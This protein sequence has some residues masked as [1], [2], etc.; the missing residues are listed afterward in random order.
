VIVAA[1]RDKAGEA[2]A[3]GAAQTFL[4]QGRRV[5]I[6]RPHA[7]YKDFNDELMAGTV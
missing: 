3:E 2:A 1:D 4:A 7:P 5:R 6:I